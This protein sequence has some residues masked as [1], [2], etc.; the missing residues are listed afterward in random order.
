LSRQIP[1]VVVRLVGE[2]ASVLPKMQRVCW[3]NAMLRWQSSA[4]AMRVQSRF[5]AVTT[6]EVQTMILQRHQQLRCLHSHFPLVEHSQASCRESILQSSIP[7]LHSL[8]HHPSFRV[9]PSPGSVCTASALVASGECT[10]Q[11]SC[12]RHYPQSYLMSFGDVVGS[13]PSRRTRTCTLRSRRSLVRDSSRL[14]R[15]LAG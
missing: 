2:G 5:G 11:F 4:L 1:S 15:R 13:G 6:V 8:P 7:G 10:G 12:I 14:L 9:R 3:V